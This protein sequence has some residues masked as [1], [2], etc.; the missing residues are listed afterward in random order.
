M[1]FRKSR[2]VANI[3][4]CVG[5]VIV[6]AGQISGSGVVAFSMAIVGLGVM[7]GGVAVIYKFWKCP[8]CYCTLPT[9]EPH[10]RYCPHCGKELE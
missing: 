1:N 3:L 4:L 9:R 7:Y 6:L 2:K 10:I 8:H 5:V